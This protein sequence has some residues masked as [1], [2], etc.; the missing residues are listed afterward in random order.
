MSI[1]LRNWKCRVFCRKV[2]LSPWSDRFA[3]D[4]AMLESYVHVVPCAV[5][6]CKMGAVTRKTQKLKSFLTC[7]LQKLRRY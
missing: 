7:Q 2:V 6:C 3:V 4:V 5:F 1:K